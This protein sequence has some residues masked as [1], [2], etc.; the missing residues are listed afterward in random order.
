MTTIIERDV[1]G[2]SG[3]SSALTAIVAIIAILFVVGIALYMLRLYPFNTLSAGTTTTPSVNVN[4]K[5]VLPAV[6]STNP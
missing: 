6:P 4:V 3:I 1:S 5:G 2:E